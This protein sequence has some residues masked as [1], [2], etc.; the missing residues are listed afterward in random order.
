MPC[1]SCQQ[2]HTLPPLIK[3]A[4]NLAGAMSRV[5]RAVVAGQPV[6]SLSEMRMR[7]LM[8]CKACE[9]YK[10][11]WCMDYTDRN[12]KTIKGCGCALAIKT[13]IASEENQCPRAKW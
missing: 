4:A 8:V 13:A 9:N 11:G 1:P 3:R 7:R 10:D 5:F 12:G 6:F 2:R